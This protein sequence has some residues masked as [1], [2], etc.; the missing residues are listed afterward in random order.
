MA[1]PST[2]NLSDSDGLRSLVRHVDRLPPAV[3]G[4][5]MKR[6]IDETGSYEGRPGLPSGATARLALG[7]GHRSLAD[8]LAWHGH[9]EA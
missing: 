9:S 1:K 8:R 2:L 5:R 6:E 4:G 7:V 3:P